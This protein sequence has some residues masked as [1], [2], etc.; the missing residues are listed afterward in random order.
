MKA[1]ILNGVLKEDRSMIKVNELTEEILAEK[2]YEVESILLHQKKIGE[3][4]GCFG[5]WVKTPGICVIDDYGRKY[6]FRASGGRSLLAR[7]T[8]AQIWNKLDILR[9]KL[10]KNKRLNKEMIKNDTAR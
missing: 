6:S 3:C 8:G 1:L 5:C 7:L 2:G 10:S 9:M 4:M